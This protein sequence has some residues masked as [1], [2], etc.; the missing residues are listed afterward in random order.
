ML[1]S[2]KMTSAYCLAGKRGAEIKAAGSQIAK[3]IHIIQAACSARGSFSAWPAHLGNSIKLTYQFLLI[4][5]QEL[6][7]Y[8]FIRMDFNQCLCTNVSLFL[9]AASALTAGMVPVAAAVPLFLPLRRLL[10][11]VVIFSSRISQLCFVP[12]YPRRK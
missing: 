2:W 9:V 11:V 4:G 12:L 5:P 8:R 1:L 10:S 6:Y 7:S 3:Q